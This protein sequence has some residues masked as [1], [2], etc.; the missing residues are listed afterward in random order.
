MYLLK[1]SP[2]EP[3]DG[4]CIPFLFQPCRRFSVSLVCS[5]QDNVLD[6]LLAVV[7]LYS[8][9]VLPKWSFMY[10]YIQYIQHGPNAA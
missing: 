3:A 7:V 1:I 9:L 5:V 8:G 10:Y 6:W 4:S 2:S